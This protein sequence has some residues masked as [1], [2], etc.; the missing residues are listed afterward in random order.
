MITRVCEWAPT[1][2]VSAHSISGES[3]TKFVGRYVATLVATALVAAPVITH[4]A[5]AATGDSFATLSSAD[6]STVVSDPTFAPKGITI[7]S[8]YV[9]DG[10]VREGL[11]CYTADWKQ[12]QQGDA[13]RNRPFYAK[14]FLEVRVRQRQQQ[15]PS[16]NAP[17]I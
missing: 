4:T 16:T 15:V 10:G 13:P 14:L 5:Q 11:L 6:L 3:M 17:N 1:D 12:K 7:A 9:Q 2:M 8:T